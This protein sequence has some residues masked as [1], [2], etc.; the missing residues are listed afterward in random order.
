MKRSHQNNVTIVIRAGL[1]NQML[2]FAAAYQVTNGRKSITLNDC[3]FKLPQRGIRFLK[4]QRKCGLDRFNLGLANA[5]INT[6][7]YTYFLCEC[8]RLIAKIRRR[9][10]IQATNTY[11]DIGLEFPSCRSLSHSHEL[12][13]AGKM[14]GYFHDLRFFQPN[15]PQLRKI[16]TLSSSE[17]AKVDALYSYYTQDSPL[18]SVV[19]HV[20]REDTLVKGNEGY[21]I[22]SIDYY[23][24][25]IAKHFSDKN[26]NILVFSDDVEW[27]KE[28]KFLNKFI[29]ITEKDPL[30]S[31][32]LMSRCHHYILAS[33]TFSWWGARLGMKPESKI[34]YP[35]PFFN[36]SDP[37]FDKYMILD[38]RRWI[39]F[40]SQF[41]EL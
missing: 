20:R 31:M 4:F 6:N 35:S 27:C 28:N 36:I 41:I 34:V 21:G 16:F 26:Y 33:S 23:R 12:K 8:S 13:T 37:L 29:L 10:M 11:C 3:F 5:T 24:N 19:L 2:Q 30:I 25:V 39:S 22:L 9:P 15:L 7:F 32:R 14:T 38:D 17:E 18:D 40:Q 1:G